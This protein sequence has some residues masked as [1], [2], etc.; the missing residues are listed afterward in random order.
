MVSAPYLHQ[1]H[2]RW[3]AMCT[4]PRNH[5]MR[6]GGAACCRPA[7]DK[8]VKRLAICHAFCSKN[9]YS[10]WLLRFCVLYIWMAHAASSLLVHSVECRNKW[11]ATHEMIWFFEVKSCAT[12][13]KRRRSSGCSPG[14]VYTNW[15][16]QGL[17][18]LRNWSSSRIICFRWQHRTVQ[19][20]RLHDFHACLSVSH[21]CFAHTED[22]A[23]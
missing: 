20:T 16:W 7:K 10:C 9:W 17:N 21:G 2:L 12:R 8:S 18:Y 23:R 13:W 3:A 4:A 1:R 14:S 19:Q 6:R 5:W 22:W 15:P 11:A